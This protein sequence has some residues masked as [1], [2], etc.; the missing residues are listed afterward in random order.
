MYVF[1]NNKITSTKYEVRR[2][3]RTKQS[4]LA[5][6]TSY[7][8]PLCLPLSSLVVFISAQCGEGYEKMN[9]GHF[10]MGQFPFYQRHN[11]LLPA[12]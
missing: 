6:R 11:M 12:G 4:H 5:P 7:F 3:L 10:Q 1:K 9:R 8:V 2:G